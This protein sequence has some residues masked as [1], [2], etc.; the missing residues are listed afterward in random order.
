M[1][2]IEEAHPTDLWQMSSNVRDGVLFESP[3]TDEERVNVAAMCVTR[4][5]VKLPA[6]LDGLDNRVERANCG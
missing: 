3:R 2:Y 1:V 4:L 6:L 5:S